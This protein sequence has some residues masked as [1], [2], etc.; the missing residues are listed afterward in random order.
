MR[1][2]SS[3]KRHGIIVRASVLL[4]KN[5]AILVVKHKKRNQEYYVLPGGHVEEFEA[6]D[7]AARRELKEECNLDV[8]LGQLQYVGNY[9][10]SDR[11][12]GIDVVFLGKSFRGKLT[13][14]HDPDKKYGLITEVRWMTF[15][16]LRKVDFRP[17]ILCKQIFRDIKNKFRKFSYL[18][19][20]P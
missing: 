4:R 12:H 20:Y 18:G 19:K 15:D 1:S 16:E 13:N 2:S 11:I 17:E 10:L 14:S 6:L 5:N 3:P 8:T 9:I 7:V